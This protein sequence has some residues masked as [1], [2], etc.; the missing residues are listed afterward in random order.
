[1]I[2][3]LVYI[4]VVV[5]IYFVHSK[6]KKWIR[7]REHKMNSFEGGRNKRQIGTILKGGNIF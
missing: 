1:M 5:Q 4:L 3:L 7:L 2:L 6:T